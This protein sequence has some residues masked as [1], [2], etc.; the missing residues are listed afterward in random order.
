MCV[1]HDVFQSL[2][3][4]DNVEYLVSCCVSAADGC[5]SDTAVIDLLAVTVD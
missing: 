2:P 1:Y 5:F 3:T 4:A